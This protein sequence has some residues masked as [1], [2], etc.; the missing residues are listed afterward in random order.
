M[1]KALKKRKEKQKA[2][3]QEKARLEKKGR[4]RAVQ[5]DPDGLAQALE[6]EQKMEDRHNQLIDNLSNAGLGSL[7]P[8][9]EKSGPT[10]DR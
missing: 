5:Y 6:H 4:H 7:G 2:K 8:E 9:K 3:K 10:I 1:F